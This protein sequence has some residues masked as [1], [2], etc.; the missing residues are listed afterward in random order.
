LWTNERLYVSRAFGGDCHYCDIDGDIDAG[1]ADDNEDKLVNGG[2]MT[3]P[4]DTVK[5]Q[6]S[7]LQTDTAN[8]EDRNGVLWIKKALA[9]IGAWY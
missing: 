8:N 7:L 6:T 9:H 2:G 3:R 5:G 1:Y 4:S